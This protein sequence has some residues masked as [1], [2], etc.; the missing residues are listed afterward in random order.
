[1]LCPVCQQPLIIVEFRHIELDSCPECDG[2]WFDA[3]ELSQL[4]ELAGAREHYRQLEAQLDRLKR[5]SPRR[6]CPRCH[7]RLLPVRAP[8][9][10]GDLILDEC[11]HGHGIWFDRGELESLLRSTLDAD[12]QSLAEV[13]AFLGRFAAPAGAPDQETH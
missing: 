2:L 4:F 11:E 13:R 7:K 9:V 5:D 1:M 8:A 10:P 12:S 3:Q 6:S